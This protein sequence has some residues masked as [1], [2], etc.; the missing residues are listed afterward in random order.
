[1]GAE[2]SVLPVVDSSKALVPVV[3]WRVLHRS[4]EV[5]TC[6]YPDSGA[7]DPLED[8]ILGP[9]EVAED[10][11]V[12]GIFEHAV[13]D[14]FR[15]RSARW[16]LVTMEIPELANREEVLPV[17][18]IESVEVELVDQKIINEVGDFDSVL[19]DVA[20]KMALM[21]TLLED[22]LGVRVTLA[23]VGEEFPAHL[24]FAFDVMFPSLLGEPGA[25][26]EIKHVAVDDDR[27]WLVLISVIKGGINSHLVVKRYVNVANQEHL[28]TDKRGV[29][30][31]LQLNYILMLQTPVI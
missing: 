6:T 25:L 22:H 28:L 21:V 5:A 9:V 29:A 10:G 19:Q 26:V 24:Q 12:Q 15:L 27:V 14:I 17:L 23:E 20:L 7:V 30:L 4:S 13:G 18:D 16:L 31:H 11:V 1:M 3:K 2:G 8:L